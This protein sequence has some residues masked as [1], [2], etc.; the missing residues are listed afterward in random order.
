M[1][2]L[3]QNLITR[4]W[5]V[6]AT[7]RAKKPEAFIVK[8]PDAGAS[9]DREP[10]CPFCPGNEMSTGEEVW[11]VPEEGDWSVRLV[12]NKFPAVTPEGMPQRK[13]SGIHR[14]MN[15]VGYHEVLVE[16][17][18]H[19]RHPSLQTA[20]E[21]EYVLAAYRRR[22]AELKSDPRIESIVIFRNHG[23]GAGTSQPHPHSQVVAMPV[24]S[25]QMRSRLEI[26]IRYFDEAGECIFCRTLKD[27]RVSGERIIL[28][29]RNFIAFVPFA[30][31]T[32]FHIWIYPLRHMSS[33]DQMTDDE[34]KDLSG[35]LR[36]VLR[37]LCV[38]LN[39]PDYNLILR[40]IP[41]HLVHTDYF[42][43]YISVVPRLS[44]Q[45]GFELGS[46]MYINPSIPEESA[47][48]LRETKA[49]SEA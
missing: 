29:S 7:E 3:R 43:W 39:D 4:D 12:R 13:L 9:L 1:A 21:M 46:G 28:S 38:G 10:S 48:F 32:P 20:E 27:E 36:T 17:P 5:V 6:I 16:H 23:Y 22:Y 19:G 8:R 15:A 45:A 26:A 24:V 41:T 14:S 11:R 40:S 33:F 34:S 44:I 35:I 37:K 30:A 42:H 49:D 18:F 2:E 31:L 25:T 47:A